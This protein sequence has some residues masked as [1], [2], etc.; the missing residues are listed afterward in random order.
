MFADCLVAPD[1]NTATASSRFP[2]DI[3]YIVARNVFA[4][5]IEI[6]TAPLENRAVLTVQQTPHLFMGALTLA[7][8]LGILRHRNSVKYR[9]NDNFRMNLVGDGFKI[10]DN[11]VAQ[12]AVA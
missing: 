10:E 2:V 4:Q 5:I 11:A 12:Y 9:I 6:E 1:S 7:K 3:F 8:R